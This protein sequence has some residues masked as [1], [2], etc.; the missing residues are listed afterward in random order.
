MKKINIRTLIIALTLPFVAGSIGSVATISSIPTWYALLI[1]PSFNPPN[2]LFGSVWTLLYVLMGVSLYLILKDWKGEKTQRKAVGIFI[3]QLV[4][5]SLWSI[6]FFGFKMPLP[7]FLEIL[8][9]WFVILLNINAFYKINKI[10][11]ILLIPYILWVS[12]AGI[13]NFA[14][15]YL[16]RI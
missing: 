15:Y 12:F 9:L 8:I 14:I 13:L 11:G 5:N 3:L 10:S 6:I 4:L 2:W 7:A 1:K 16:N